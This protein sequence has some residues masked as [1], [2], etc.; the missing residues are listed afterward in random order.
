MKQKC[1]PYFMWLLPLSFFAYQFILRL[2]PSL[3]MHQIMETFMIDATSFGLLASAYYYGYAGMQIPI[4]IM[5]EKYGP[6]YIIFICTTICGIAML[7]FTYTNNWYLALLSRALIGVGSAVGF[8]G[9][10][11]VIAQWFG[12]EKYGS[13]VGFSFTIGLLGAIYGGRPVS[14]LMNQVGLKTLSLILALIPIA[15]GILILCFLRN[16]KVDNDKF[17][18]ENTANNRLITDNEN[19]NNLSDTDIETPKN[20]IK[21]QDLMKVIKSP[22]ICLLALANLLL[23]GSLEGFTDVWGVNYMVKAYDIEKNDAATLLSFVFVGMLFGGPLLNLLSNKISKY[24]V[25]GL[26]GIGITLIF[27]IILS[28]K[29]FHWMVMAG[30]LFLLGILC[31]YQV[32]IFALGSELV[33]RR[34]L[35]ITIAF[36]NC[37]NMLGGSFFHPIIGIL[38]DKFWQGELCEEVRIYP[39]DAYIKALIII[40]VCSLL[41]ALITFSIMKRK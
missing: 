8:L 35:G 9:T 5:L 11:A 6:R 33:D 23:V 28:M 13:M 1:I 2:W 26:C 19:S 30:L 32:V 12:K 20:P 27:A 18:R 15:I 24:K 36:F 14:I 34:S 40:P 39:T 7:I 17:F 3:T 4:A 25:I 38:M 16:K 37:I 31:C 41:G 29:N 21:L 10:S 22:T